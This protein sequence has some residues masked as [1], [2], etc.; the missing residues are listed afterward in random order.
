MNAFLCYCSKQLIKKIKKTSGVWK[1]SSD[2]LNST[3][4][5]GHV[6]VSFF[7]VTP[8]NKDAVTPNPLTKEEAVVFTTVMTS[9]YQLNTGFSKVCEILKFAA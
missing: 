9:A 4:F 2:W 3:G 6:C 7:N 1:S 8:G 5:P